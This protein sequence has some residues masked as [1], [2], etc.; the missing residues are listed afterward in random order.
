MLKQF[1]KKQ[2]SNPDFIRMTLEAMGGKTSG[3]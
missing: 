3:K 1:D 2:G